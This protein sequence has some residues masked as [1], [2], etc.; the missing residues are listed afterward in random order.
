MFP[1]TDIFIALA[2]LLVFAGFINKFKCLQ[3]QGLRSWLTVALLGLKFIAGLAL[4]YIYTFHYTDVRNNDA[5]KF[6][7]DA[8]VLQQIRTENSEAFTHFMIG[9]PTAEEQE[10]YGGR[11]LNWERNFDEAPVNENRTAIRLNALFL[12]ITGKSY[13]AH[14]AIF[15]FLSL[16]GFVWMV[17]SIFKNV[18]PQNKLLAYLVL[19]LPSVLFWNSGVMKEPVLIFGLGLFIAGLTRLAP[20]PVKGGALLVTGML[21]LLSIKFY[22]LLCLLPAALAYLL[23]TAKGA[24]VFNLLKYG[25]IYL[26]VFIGAFS[27]S[28][29]SRFNLPQMLVNKQEHAIKEAGYFN[30]GSRIAI[31][32]ITAQA[33]SIV[34]VIPTAVFNTLM[35][36]LPTE[37]KNALMQMNALEN[38]LVLLLLCYC[39]WVYRAGNAANLWLFLLVGSLSYFALIGICTPVIGN[40]VRYKAPLLPIFLF[41][42]ILTAQLPSLPQ[43]FQR[44]FYA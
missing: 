15:C 19:L 3:L 40:L 17:N 20:S 24:P 34:K 29:I 5:H 26:L 42:F 13:F 33:G 1:A 7:S 35:R 38:L 12:F 36:P 25:C 8:V 14:I 16:A 18:A 44:L 27:L 2:F 39:I 11:L 32:V 43:K 4:W 22:V 31:P 23:F 21:V 37:G 9:S 30:A 6:F 10:Q 28:G 41:A